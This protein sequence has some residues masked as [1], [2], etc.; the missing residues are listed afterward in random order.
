VYWSRANSLGGLLAVICGL[1]VWIGYEIFAPKSILPPQLAGLIA[2]IAGML[3][4][5]L[6]PKDML[7]VV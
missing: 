7:K 4:G 5:S 6:L 3:L 2:S 1:T